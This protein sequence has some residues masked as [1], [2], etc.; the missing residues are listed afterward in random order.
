ML[1]RLMSSLPCSLLLF[2]VICS[3]Q[4]K[5]GAESKPAKNAAFT[6]SALAAYDSIRSLND[7]ASAPEVGFQPRQ[8]EA[9]KNLATAEHKVRTDE[10]RRQFEVLK[11]WMSVISWY[12]DFRAPEHTID[13]EAVKREIGFSNARMYCSIEADSIFNPSAL[14]DKSR[15]T[16]ETHHCAAEA[17]AAMQNAGAQVE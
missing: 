16:A 5:T 13:V 12:R 15:K 9:E 4:M 6:A 2:G 3:A 14:N 10:D 1:N 11:T 8:I 17:K 7:N